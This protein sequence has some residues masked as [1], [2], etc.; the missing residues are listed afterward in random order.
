M[1]RERKFRLKF[2]SDSGVFYQINI[3]D[4]EA[5]NSNL[6]EPNVGADGFNLTYKTKDNDRFTG[7]IPSELKFD[8]FI[9]NA[10]QQNEINLIKASEYGRWQ[11]EIQRANND[12]EAEYSLYWCGNILNDIN[13]EEDKDYPRSFRLTAVCGLAPLQD[14]PFNQNV[15]YSAPSTYRVLQYFRYAFSLQVETNVFWGATDT[16]LATFVDWTT[17]GLTHQADRDPLVYSRFNFMAFVELG[18]NGEKKFKSAFE[19]LDG[20]CKAFGMRCFFFFFIWNLVK[21]NYY[22]NLIR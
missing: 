15:G 18:E 9:E 13:P 1:A 19:L 11:L 4:N 2:Q 20:I 14:V 12:V 16:Y 3:F 5:I 7:L 10:A 6:Y 22:D 17:D 21:V 8:I